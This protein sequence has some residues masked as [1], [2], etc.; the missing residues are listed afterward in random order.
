MKNDRL[1]NLV[2][3]AVGSAIFNFRRSPRNETSVHMDSHNMGEIWAWNLIR[4]ELSPEVRA[5]VVAA[6]AEISEVSA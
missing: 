4:D 2:A 5:Q 3:L 6:Y 1:N